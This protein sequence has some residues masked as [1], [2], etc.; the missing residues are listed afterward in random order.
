MTRI[1]VVFFLSTHLQAIP[2]EYLFHG[3]QTPLV[4][5]MVDVDSDWILGHSGMRCFRM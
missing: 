1:N 4:P 2:Y 3:S 5:F